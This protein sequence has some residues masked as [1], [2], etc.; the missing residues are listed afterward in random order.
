M[1]KSMKDME[2]TET[3]QKLIDLTQ[4]KYELDIKR[5]NPKYLDHDWLLQSIADELEEVR[6]EI[7]PENLHHLE[8]ELGDV[9]W[10]WL[11]LVQ[12]LEKQGYAGSHEAILKRTLKKYQERIVPLQG[13]MGDDLIWKEVK[14]KQKEV[15][16]KEKENCY[17]ELNSSP[18]N[19]D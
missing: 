12:K 19:E 1:M 4:H 3:L 8:D 18:Q 2:S 10:G 17:N 16:K 9:L 7:K 6:E 14:A 5:N 15:L 13:T 11:I